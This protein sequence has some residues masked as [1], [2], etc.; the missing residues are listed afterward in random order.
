MRV[1]PAIVEDLWFVLDNLSEQNRAELATVGLAKREIEA[2]YTE[3]LLGEGAYVLEDDAPLTVFG[4]RGPHN[5]MWSAATDEYFARPACVLASRRAL[6]EFRKE[7]GPLQLVTAGGH[8]NTARWLTLLG[9]EK[10]E[11]NDGLQSFVYR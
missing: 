7:R 3:W 4:A 8:E 9:Y 6:R 2:Q 11:E 1:R 10:V 5:A